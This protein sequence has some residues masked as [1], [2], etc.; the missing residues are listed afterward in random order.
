MING[1]LQLWNLIMAIVGAL[2]VD[3]VGRRSL[4]LLSTSI[5]LVSYIIITGLSGGFATTKSY[6]MGISVIPFLFLYYAGYDIA[7]T[8][9]LMSYPAEIWQ[10]SL[11]AKGVALTS[12]CTYFALLFNSFVNPIALDAIHWKYYIVYIALLVL[13]LVCIYVMYPETRG[14][15]LENMAAIFDGDGASYSA[16]LK[17]GKVNIPEVDHVECQISEHETAHR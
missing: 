1:F 15:S 2:L 10:F 17:S 11:R 5:M 12:A 6:S 8:P 13:I 3:R 14:H 9:L 4:F 7:F 16:G